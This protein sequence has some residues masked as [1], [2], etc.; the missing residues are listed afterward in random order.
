MA[1]EKYVSLF[2]ALAFAKTAY[3]I[4]HPTV[5]RVND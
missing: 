1:R 4:D 2:G 3:Y 5:H